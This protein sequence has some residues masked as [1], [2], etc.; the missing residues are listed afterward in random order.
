MSVR[1]TLSRLG[2][3]VAHEVVVNVLAAVAVGAMAFVLL[4]GRIEDLYTRLR[5]NAPV[6]GQ[7]A[8]VTIDEEAFYLWNPYDPA[9]E[10]TPR[11]MLAEIVR[12]LQAAGARV[13]VLDIL[14]DQ[15]A[16]GDDALVASVQAHGRVVAA[17]RVSP[18]RAD[19]VSPVAPATVL[20]EV[21][22]PAYANLGLEEQTLFSGQ[23]TVRAVPLVTSVSRAR[24]SGPFPTGLVGGFQDDESP[25]PSL[26]LASA[27]M[28]LTTNPPGDLTSALAS[29]C[30]GTPVVCTGDAADLGLPETGV[31]LHEPLG[32]NLRG[33]E[34]GDGIPSVSAARLLRSL[35]ESALARTIGVDLP[36]TV[37]ADIGEQLK[38][39]VV[40]VGRVDAGA[41]DQ[42]V[43]SYS[44][45]AMQL[46]DMS[47]ARVHA[48][49]IDTLL[50]GRHLRRVDGTA[51][52]VG[53]AVLGLLCLL[54]GRRAASLHLL[55]WG[56]VTV[57][58]LGGGIAAFRMFDGLVLDVAPALAVLTC[59]LVAVHLYARAA[60]PESE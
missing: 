6:S 7:V 8:L 28:Q 25:A 33:P 57:A 5:P 29:R 45:P 20:G 17:E 48:Q 53:A 2:R 24:L 60:A 12:F 34:G 19:D 39:R 16:T 9:P 22:L 54:T 27:W 59:A 35:G 15:P 47:G 52:W 44:F 49:L 32:L 31:P 56:L 11:A 36:I 41:N 13:V 10:T 18:G 43:T 30:G 40:V 23:M 1:D 38:G 3:D 46:A 51:A 42:F 21:A 50:T 14:T 58:L 37:P 26:A 55:G 4:G